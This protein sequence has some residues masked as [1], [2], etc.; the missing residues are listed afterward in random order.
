MRLFGSL[1]LMVA[2]CLG[3]P[4]ALA[5]DLA[6]YWKNDDQPA[7]MEIRIVEESATGTVRRNDQDPAAVGRVL[8]KDVVSEEDKPG[9]WRG[10]IYARRLGE[11]RDAEITL[12]D[13]EHMRIEVNV[14]LLNR[15]VRWT[16]VA[17][18]P[19]E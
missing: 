19:R 11:Y 12:V 9:T 3:S 1:L 10:R 4:M 7:W 15:A 18:L 5:A 2:G 14:G 16:R 17:A 6:G 13:S 8:L